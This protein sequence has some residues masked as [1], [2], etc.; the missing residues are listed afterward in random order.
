MTDADAEKVKQPVQE[1]FQDLEVE[2]VEVNQVTQRLDHCCRQPNAHVLL[3]AETSEVLAG[4]QHGEDGEEQFSR[5]CIPELCRERYT[6][7]LQGA[8]QRV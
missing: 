3:C 6:I 2:G 1:P 8:E 4:L 7:L 5:D